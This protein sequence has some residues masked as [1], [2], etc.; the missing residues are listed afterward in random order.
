MRHFLS[1]ALGLILFTACAFLGCSHTTPYIG[2]ESVSFSQSGNVQYRMIAIGDAGAQ[3]EEEPVSQTLVHW[4]SRL[5]EKTTIFFLGDNI[6]EHGMPSES[7]SEKPRAMQRINYQV[8]SVLQSKAEGI[9]I[10]GNHD[11]ANQS[12]LAN[13]LSQQSHLDSIL[14]EGSFLPRDGCP[15]PAIV[16]RESFRFILLDTQWWLVD[17]GHCREQNQEDVLDKI[18]VALKTSEDKIP[19]LLAHHP[20]RTMGHHGGFFSWQDHIFPL[21]N[22]PGKK[23]L[24]FPLP[25]V[26]SLYPL[27]NWHLFKTGQD[28]IDP[29][30]KNMI[31]QMDS[32]LQEHPPLAFVAGHEHN[33]QV[34]KESDQEHYHV[35]S[36]SGS[37]S[38]VTDVSHNAHTLFA[39]THSGFMVFDLMNDGR[40]LLH[41][42]EAGS[43]TPIW[44]TQ[45]Q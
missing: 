5:P 39:Y 37:Q 27:L 23:W 13:I 29:P 10:P 42:I 20:L 43:N 40:V 33:L 11:W 35:V 12:Q 41:V 34:F 22:L 38:K 8:H 1:F 6:Y 30:Y 9:F 18:K 26:G 14:G 17:L 24:W 44:S 36:G 21:R 32:L 25:G 7:D 45:L 2:I 19:I 3:T 31:H 16:D 4:A 28:I 15:G